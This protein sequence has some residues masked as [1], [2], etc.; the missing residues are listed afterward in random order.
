[1]TTK[2]TEWGMKQGNNFRTF[3]IQANGRMVHAL[4]AGEGPLVIALH[5]F[6]DL[7]VSFRH[8]I[9][10]LAENGYRVIAPCLRGYSVSDAASD[11]PFDVAILVQDL[12]ALVDQLADQPVV[13]IG[14]DWGA[15]I[16]RGAAIMAP[17]KVAKI[18]SM[19]V[20]TA[21]NFGRALL[22]NPTQQRR[23]WYMYFFQLPLAEMAVAHND[24]EFIEQLWKEWS[25][26]WHCPQPVMDEI[27]AAFRHPSVLKAAL[28]Y[29]RSQFN[30]ALQHPELADIRKRL[31]DPIPVPAMHLHG[32]DD[33][34]IGAETTIG[35]ESAFIKHFEK[36]VIPSAGHFVHQEQPDVVNRLIIDFLNRQLD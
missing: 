8:Q 24:F 36:H 28:G 11:G 32:A 14:H 21:G 35:M 1:M 4:E 12:L 16:V 7:P 19:S 17:A 5:G 15:S 3:S 13:L 29:Y 18:I 10:L 27:K 25:P 33:G 20:P 31:S 26:G 23:S 22:T 2:D 9:P 6:P 30:H 34:C